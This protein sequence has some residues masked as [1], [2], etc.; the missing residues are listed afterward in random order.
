MSQVV[1][2]YHKTLKFLKS[3]LHIVLK[4]GF[5]PS[6]LYFLK[7]LIHRDFN[8]LKSYPVIIKNYIN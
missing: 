8:T 5:L 3:T 2:Y 6:K 7:L 1:E 4:L